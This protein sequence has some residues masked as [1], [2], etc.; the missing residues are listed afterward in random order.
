MTQQVST[1][2]DAGLI[3]CDAAGLR[4][5]VQ[6]V[7]HDTIMRAR[8]AAS[9]QV[10]YKNS[11]ERKTSDNA[12][13]HS[14]ILIFPKIPFPQDVEEIKQ[15]ESQVSTDERLAGRKKGLGQKT[16]LNPFLVFRKTRT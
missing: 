5:L 4:A 14:I 11:V 1:V 10:L 7:I 2:L 9:L 8:I 12:F 3:E 13:R 15:L 6:N 16:G